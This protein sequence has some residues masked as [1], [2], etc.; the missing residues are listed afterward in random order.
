M[1][2]KRR[3]RETQQKTDKPKAK[4]KAPAPPADLGRY[5]KEYWRYHAQLL[6]DLE[7]LTP[8]HL[9]T[10]RVLCDQWQTYRRLTVWLEADPGRLTFTTENGYEQETPQ[11]R[12]RDKALDQMQKLWLKFGLT[13]H[14]LATLNKQRGNKGG[15]LSSEIE[16]FAKEKYED[17]P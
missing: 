5:G 3:G 12:L 2:K 14:A 16:R 8:L 15:P 7:I 9:R 11:V 10:F 6:A 1:A 17:E 13:P 4:F